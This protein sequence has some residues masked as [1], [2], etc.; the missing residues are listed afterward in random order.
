[1]ASIVI[2]TPTLTLIL[3]MGAILEYP[4][5]ASHQAILHF[6]GP[7]NMVAGGFNLCDLHTTDCSTQSL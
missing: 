7:T 5:C 2:L 6:M 3:I 1:M 4:C